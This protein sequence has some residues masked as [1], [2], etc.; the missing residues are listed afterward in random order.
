MYLFGALGKNPQKSIDKKWVN[1]PHE[2]FKHL[3]NSSKG[4]AGEEFI[5]RY[6]TSL[7]FIVSDRTSRLGDWDLRINDKTFEVKTATEDIS[8]SFQF[9]HVRYDS[10][11]EFLLCF[12]V[13]PKTLYFRIWSKADVTTGKAGNLVSMGKNQNAS[14]KL[15]KKPTHLYEILQFK[16]KLDQILTLAS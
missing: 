15:T 11:Y 16:D 6:A 13:A 7:G 14:F 2:A 10:R 8:G 12:G 5:R 3:A 9:N 1:A 4:D